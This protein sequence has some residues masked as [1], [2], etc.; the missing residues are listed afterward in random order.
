MKDQYDIEDLIKTFEE[1]SKTLKLGN[2][3]SICL[4]LKSMCEEIIR[5]RR[6]IADVE[7]S[8]DNHINDT[9]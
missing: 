8:I 1:H 7:D 5:L 3:F 6:Y 9:D 2:D 4:A